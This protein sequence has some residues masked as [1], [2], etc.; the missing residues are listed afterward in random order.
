MRGTRWLLLV[1]LI[2]IVCG[3][4]LTYRAQ[5][6][7]QR[8]QAI[9]KPASLPDDL[10]STA[11]NWTYTETN[12]NQTTIEIVARDMKRAKD[13]SHVDLKDL[14]LKTHNKNGQTYNLIKSAAASFFQNEH[15]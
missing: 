1:A 15:R 6:R 8:E 7:L 9:P 11:Q 10:D 2:A 13:A 4:G 5:K 3:V 14:V 12:H